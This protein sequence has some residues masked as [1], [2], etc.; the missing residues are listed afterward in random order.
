[1]PPFSVSWKTH[2]LR[3]VSRQ[4]KPG[5]W[6]ASPFFTEVGTAHYWNRKPSE[7]GLCDPEDDPAIMESYYLTIKTM[8][9]YEAHLQQKAIDKQ[10]R[11]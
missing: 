7:L 3:Q 11:K 6:R 2:T 4:I 9:A 5:N 10:G 1:M 8:E